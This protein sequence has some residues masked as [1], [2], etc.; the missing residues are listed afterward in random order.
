MSDVDTSKG[1]IHLIF[2]NLVST[3]KRNKH[4]NLF[5][6]QSHALRGEREEDVL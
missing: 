6:D 5:K 1:E 3:S 2:K 4:T